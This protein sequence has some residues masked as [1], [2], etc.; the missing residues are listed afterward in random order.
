VALGAEEVVGGWWWGGRGEMRCMRDDR[1]RDKDK[2]KD[3]DRET[4]KK[5][6]TSAVSLRAA[7]CAS[8]AKR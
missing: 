7:T 2:D 1:N 6:G 4:D 5:R 8:Y 3:R